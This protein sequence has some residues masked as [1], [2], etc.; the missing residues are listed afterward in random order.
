MQP[1]KNATIVQP[2]S[3]GLGNVGVVP[4]VER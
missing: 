3:P 1:A 4:F 2:M